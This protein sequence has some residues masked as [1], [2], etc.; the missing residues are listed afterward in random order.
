MLVQKGK[1]K[2]LKRCTLIFTSFHPP[3]LV[4]EPRGDPWVPSGVIEDSLTMGEAWIDEPAAVGVVVSSL[5]VIYHFLPKRCKRSRMESDVFGAA[6]IR[7]PYYYT[8]IYIDTRQGNANH[9][10]LVSVRNCICERQ[11]CSCA[12]THRGTIHPAQQQTV[13]ALHTPHGWNKPNASM[14]SS[15]GSSLKLF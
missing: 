2:K 11:L 8:T 7:K 4:S 15:Q 1:K 5:E 13:P 3:H 14:D 6:S 10:G 12:M 9:W